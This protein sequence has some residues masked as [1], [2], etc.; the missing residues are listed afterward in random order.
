V[1]RE[2]RARRGRVTRDS[3]L[4]S[5]GLAGVFYET[6]FD[7]ADRPTL[8]LL[9]GAMM[10]LPAFLRTDEQ[11][12]SRHS[13]NSLPP[14]SSTTPPSSTPSPFDLAHQMQQIQQIELQT[15]IQQETIRSMNPPVQTAPPPPAPSPPPQDQGDL[16]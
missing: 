2:R 9:F 15:E 8:L 12:R 10:G 11:V 6:I 4:F 7:K 14:P 13:S 1:T 16:Q 5:A 3:V